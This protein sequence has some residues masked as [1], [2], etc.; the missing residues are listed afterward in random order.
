VAETPEIDPGRVIADLRELERR[1]AD[2]RGAQRVCWTEPWREARRLLAGLLAELGIE[3]EVD[4]AGNL[5]A[6]LEGAD[7]RAPALV[8]GSHLDSVP[9]GGWLDGALGVMAA[10]GVLRAYAEDRRAPPHPL[11][12]VDWA[13]EEGARFGNSLFGSSAFA[14]TLD[15]QSL[16][17]LRD[18]DGRPIATVLGEHGVELAHAPRCGERRAGV[19]S[20]LELHIEQGPRMEAGGVRVAAVSGCV[21][22]E[23]CRYAFRGQAAQA[24][25][26]PI[27]DRRDAGLAAATAAL[28]IERLAVDEAGVATTGELRIEPGIATAVPGRAIL[29]VDLRHPEAAA[30][31][32][33]LARTR[34][35]TRAAADSR[36]CELTETA[37]WRIEPIDFDPGLVAA[38]RASCAA[39]AEEP[40]ELV[41]GALHDAAAVARVLPAA[42][43]FAPSRAGISHAVEED[44][45]EADLVLAIEALTELA[46]RALA[47][48]D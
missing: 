17:E 7:P 30:L 48:E 4:E 19:G 34:E 25:T 5:W 31:E 6:R 10:L 26:T 9:D 47:R 2:D 33:M 40:A 1:T 37:I 29:S 22:V 24:G 42:M 20:Y 3:P 32:R 16:G 35:A 46:A 15:P 41:S 44:T 45:E 18:V 38:A 21:G 23:R 13:D 11:V 27:E 28:A 14:G 39:L 36:G 8:L 43:L 12:L